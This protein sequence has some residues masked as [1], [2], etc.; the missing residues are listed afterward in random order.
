MEKQEIREGVYLAGTMTTV[1]AGYPI[2]SI[3]NT[4]D[5]TVE[6][7][8][9]VL[10]VTEVKPDSPLETSGEGNTG[11]YLDRPGEVLKRLWLEHLN[12]EGK[13]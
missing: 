9:P 7:E 10:K 1:Q 3:A 13:R 4:T 11:R 8:E 6:I 5:E 12:I 2:T